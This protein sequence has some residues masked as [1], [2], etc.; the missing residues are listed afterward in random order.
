[1]H[2]SPICRS[3]G[4]SQRR[5]C[6]DERRRPM[7]TGAAPRNCERSPGATPSPRRVASDNRP[8]G[9]TGT[10]SDASADVFRQFRSRGARP[11]RRP[12]AFRGAKG[13]AATHPAPRLNPATPPVRVSGASS[14]VSEE[15]PV[16]SALLQ[17]HVE[18]VRVA[19]QP[20]AGGRTRRIRPHSSQLAARSVRRRAEKASGEPSRRTRAARTRANRRRATTARRRAR[21]GVSNPV[22]HRG[23]PGGAGRIRR[24]VK[25]RPERRADPH[26]ATSAQP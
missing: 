12:D 2:S 24:E 4:S 11:E 8:R 20:A 22:E 6:A 15:T 26:A 9:L 18:T 14:R 5:C 16:S 1:M 7:R 10:I 23:P 25:A 17:P 19:S 3:L 13:S 21:R